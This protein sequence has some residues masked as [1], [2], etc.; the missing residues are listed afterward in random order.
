MMVMLAAAFAAYLLGIIGWEAAAIGAGVVFILANVIAV[1]VA[2][3]GTLMK[4]WRG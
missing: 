3:G 1:I 4:F 2:T